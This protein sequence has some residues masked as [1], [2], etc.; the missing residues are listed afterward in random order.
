MVADCYPSTT[1]GGGGGDSLCRLQLII[2]SKIKKNIVTFFCTNIWMRKILIN[3][4]Y[5]ICKVFKLVKY[6]VSGRIVKITIWCT[7]ICYCS[8]LKCATRHACV[9]RC[10]EI[11]ILMDTA[12]KIKPNES[13]WSPLLKVAFRLKMTVGHI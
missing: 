8:Y 13:P 10:V 11:L 9:F 12:C 5:I 3:I 4:Y 2:Y 6:P 7:P 1:G